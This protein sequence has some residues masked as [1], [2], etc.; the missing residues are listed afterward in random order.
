MKVFWG[1]I[2]ATAAIT[3]LI[4][5]GT[6]ALMKDLDEKHGNEPKQTTTPVVTS[7]VFDHSDSEEIV[8][9]PTEAPRA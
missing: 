2:A 4:I 3:A 1:V 5:V 7:Y 9:Q 6:S 8:A